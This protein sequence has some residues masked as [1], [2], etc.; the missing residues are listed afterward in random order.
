MAKVA[1]M[2]CEKNMDQCPLTAC[3]ACLAG[4]KEGFSM[5]DECT[6]SGVFTCH[7]PGD[8][9]PELARI[10]QQKGAEVIHFCTCTFANKTD[11]GWK[12]EGG[13]FCPDIDSIIERVHNDTGIPCVKGTA[14][15]PKGYTVQK[16]G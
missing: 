2:R 6:L 9:T 7:C 11:Q 16:W 4:R 12:L 5:Y 3:F 14:H 8:S 10:L 1:I 15:L 13:G